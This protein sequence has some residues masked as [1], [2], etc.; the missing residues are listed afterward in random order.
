MKAL[1]KRTKPIR[2]QLSAMSAD[3]QAKIILDVFARVCVKGWDTKN[4][5]GDWVSGIAFVENQPLLPFS[6]E[7]VVMV[8]TE[9]P[10]MYEMLLGFASDANTYKDEV[11]AAD[12]GN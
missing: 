11:L 7:N 10:D 9:L 8:F 2:R 5:D 3:A 1:E 12:V 6:P 4:E